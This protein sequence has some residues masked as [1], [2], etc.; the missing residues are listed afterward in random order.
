MLEVIREAGRDAFPSFVRRLWGDGRER[1]VEAWRGHNGPHH[2][3][4]TGIV[5]DDNFVARA[6]MIQ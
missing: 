2:R 6:H 3:P 5:F 4:R 1:F